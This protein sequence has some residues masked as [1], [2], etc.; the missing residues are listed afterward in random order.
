ME[1]RNGIISGY[2]V[3]VEGPNCNN[4]IKQEM[5]S[6][7]TSFEVSDLKPFT[8]YTFSVF[9]KTRAGSGPVAS[10]SSTTPEEGESLL[11]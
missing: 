9:A 8:S 3:E 7:S 11:S 6:N 10:I 5:D 2:V 4:I 1:E